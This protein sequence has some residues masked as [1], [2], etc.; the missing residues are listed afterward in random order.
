MGMFIVNFDN[1][2]NIMDFAVRYF[3][4]ALLL[5]IPI[6]LIIAASAYK[7]KYRELDKKEHS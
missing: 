6:Y 7:K 1:P 2:S 3:F 5:G 4:L